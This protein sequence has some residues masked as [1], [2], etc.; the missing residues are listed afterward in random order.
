LIRIE[1]PT[2][3]D[4]LDLARHLRRRDWFLVERG[5]EHWDVCFRLDPRARRRA[6]AVIEATR[7]WADSHDV[8]PI[9]HLADRDVVIQSAGP[10]PR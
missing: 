2:C 7:Q 8:D 9:V 3:R 10:H 6:Q 1:T 5:H 4:A